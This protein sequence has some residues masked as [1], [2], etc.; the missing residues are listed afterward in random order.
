[1]TP[2]TIII[3]TSGRLP[4]LQSTLLS[5]G[6]VLVPDDFSVELVLVENGA[7][8]GAEELLPCIPRRSFL[9]SEIFV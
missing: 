5:L 6:S 9:R 8:A 1:M 3:A 2:V 7:R 4:A